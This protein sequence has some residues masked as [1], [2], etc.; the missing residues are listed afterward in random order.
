MA[1][2]Q[3]LRILV[4]DDE[5]TIRRFLKATL[6]SH[7]YNVFEAANGKEALEFSV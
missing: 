6:I 2:Q 1:D 5:K 3:K 4:V 7:D